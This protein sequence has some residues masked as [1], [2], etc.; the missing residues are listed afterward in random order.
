MSCLPNTMLALRIQYTECDVLSGSLTFDVSVPSNRL[1][2]AIA[3]YSCD[4]G[5]Q[6]TSGSTQRSCLA[7]LFWN[8]TKPTC[9]KAVC[10]V[11]YYKVCYNCDIVDS[12]CTSVNT[13]TT[14]TFDECRSSAT[15]S[16]STFVEYTSSSCKTLSC[17]VP[18]I[19]YTNGNVV[20][21]PSC[22]EGLIV[23]YT[24]IPAT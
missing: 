19:A 12:G 8:G 6:L 22:N 9:S 18:Q 2:G 11:T 21:F 1:V 7:S 3:E 24:Q 5:Y 10:P 13:F 17:Q 15:I 23:V 16:N 14:A 20:I 4:I